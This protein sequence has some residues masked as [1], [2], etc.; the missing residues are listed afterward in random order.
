MIKIKSS[1]KSFN[2]KNLKKISKHQLKIQMKQ[3]KNQKQKE[4]LKKIRYRISF[5][6][7][8]IK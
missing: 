1:V 3:F 2:N 4:I 7:K 8:I 6:L 5:K